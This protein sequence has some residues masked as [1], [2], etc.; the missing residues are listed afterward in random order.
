MKPLIIKE[1]PLGVGAPKTIVPL[2]STQQ[3]DLAAQ[4]R[5]AVQAGADCLEWRIDFLDAHVSPSEIVRQAAALTN[6]YPHNPVLVTFRSKEQGGQGS[7]SS[8]DQVALITSLIDEHA[9][10]LVDIE[11]GLGERAV[12]SLTKAARE[13]GVASVVSFHDFTATPPSDDIV[14][15]IRQMRTWGADIAKVATMARAQSDAFELMR[16]AAVCARADEGPLVAIAMGKAGVIT[17]LAGET[18]GSALTF[19][20]VSETSAPGQVELAEARRI[21]NLLHDALVHDELAE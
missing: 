18:F 20:S 13:Q 8:Q 2:M 17:R 12:R 6:A 4:A 1:I 16:V 9:A 21:I 3:E 15:L 11:I 19:C 14:E 10:D 7:L 5:C